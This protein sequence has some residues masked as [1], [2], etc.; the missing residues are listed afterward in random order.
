M[1][2]RQPLQFEL[3]ESRCLMDAGLLAELAGLASEVTA[4]PATT[5]EPLA[6]NALSGLLEQAVITDYSVAVENSPAEGRNASIAATADSLLA[7]SS[8]QSALSEPSDTVADEP[9]DTSDGQAAL[10]ADLLSAEISALLPDE[11]ANRTLSVSSP[12]S[13]APETHFTAVVFLRDEDLLFDTGFPDDRTH[14]PHL[15][16]AGL[17]GNEDPSHT[18]PASDEQPANPEDSNDEE[19]SPT[20]AMALDLFYWSLS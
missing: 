8:E 6:N 1:G 15:R 12:P 20:G 18:E 17:P 3:L 9:S 7:V 16:G 10:V 4:E 2:R 14:D 13:S 11:P 19:A 5:E